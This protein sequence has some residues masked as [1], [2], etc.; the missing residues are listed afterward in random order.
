MLHQKE[1]EHSNALSS[2]CHSSHLHTGRTQNCI[3][4]AHNQ[5]YMWPLFRFIRELDDDDDDDDADDDDADDDAAD[6][7]EDED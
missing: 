3:R 7:D 2:R 6:D 1:N 4:R 5:T